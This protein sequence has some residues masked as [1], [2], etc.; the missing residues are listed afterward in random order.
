MNGIQNCVQCGREIRAWLEPSPVC[1]ECV[2]LRERGTLSGRQ[3]LARR[4]G[5][6]IRLRDHNRAMARVEAGDALRARRN[7]EAHK[8]H[9]TARWIRDG[10]L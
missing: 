2:D 7:I 1:A 5:A 8:H 9:R 4:I 6:E 3:L 10:I